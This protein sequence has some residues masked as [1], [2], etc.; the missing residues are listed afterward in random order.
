LTWQ[1]RAVFNPYSIQPTIDF[2][3]L[4]D[5]ISLAIDTKYA[6]ELKTQSKCFY[7]QQFDLLNVV[8]CSCN[9]SGDASEKCFDSYDATSTD[10]VNVICQGVN[11]S[12]EAN[13]V[14]AYYYPDTL[15][16]DRTCITIELSSV[17]IGEFRFNTKVSL[18]A[19]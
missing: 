18:Q 7:G 15:D 16:A 4:Y 17:S 12:L 9:P 6:F 5:D 19:R 1:A 13:N 2:L 8:T 11:G 14:V 3:S 10:A